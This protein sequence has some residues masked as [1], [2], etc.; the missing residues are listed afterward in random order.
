MYIYI[1]IYIY[2]HTNNSIVY[3]AHI[4]LSNGKEGHIQTIKTYL[5]VLQMSMQCISIA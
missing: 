2:T 4:A 3:T 5:V 1:Y